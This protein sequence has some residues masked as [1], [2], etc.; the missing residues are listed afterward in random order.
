MDDLLRGRRKAC[1]GVTSIRSVEQLP[2]QTLREL[3]HEHAPVIKRYIRPR[4][5]DS[6][7]RDE[8]FQNVWL[9]FLAYAQRTPVDNAGG[10]LMRLAVV[11]VKVWYGRS[12]KREIA[13]DAIG[14]SCSGDPLARRE[15]ELLI[16]QLPQGPQEVELRLDLSKALSE[17][18]PRDRLV[19]SL[20]YVD[21]LTNSEV[22]VAL[23]VSQQ[24]VHQIL[25]KALARLKVSEHLRNYGRDSS[26][27]VGG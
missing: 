17:L 3:F 18:A 14:T 7:A 10:F 6:G 27:E 23:G 8:V 24:R 25:S 21:G 15:C 11:Q 19:L 13:S 9:G 5:D 1:N 22:G 2:E 20:T 26:K 16:R 12:V 4:I